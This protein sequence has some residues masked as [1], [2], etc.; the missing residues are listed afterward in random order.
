LEFKIILEKIL[1][2][3]EMSVDRTLHKVKRKEQNL[4]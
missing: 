3:V 2:Q 4:V 1:E